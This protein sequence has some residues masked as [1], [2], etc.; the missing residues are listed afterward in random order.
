MYLI[1]ELKIDDINNAGLIIRGYSISL[2][3]WYR[4]HYKFKISSNEKK[5]K[6]R[7]DEYSKFNKHDAM[8][9]TD[10]FH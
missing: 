5:I 10:Y 4:F 6:E 3:V 2:K 9:E 7:N 1:S 8:L